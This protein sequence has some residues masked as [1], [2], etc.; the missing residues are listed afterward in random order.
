[1]YTLAVLAGHI[2][3]DDPGFAY[4]CSDMMISGMEKAGIDH[5][6]LLNTYIRA[7]NLCIE[8]RPSDLTVG[9]H[10][11]RGNFTVSFEFALHI[12]PPFIFTLYLR[13]VYISVRGVMIVSP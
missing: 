4:F 3:F 5:E 6:V 10:V 8:D 11:C 12:F 13:A 7:I 9:V 1:M 2:Q